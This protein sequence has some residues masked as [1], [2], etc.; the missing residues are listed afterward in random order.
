VKLPNSQISIILIC[1]SGTNP[2]EQKSKHQ[3]TENGVM[4]TRK[5]WGKTTKKNEGGLGGW[6]NT[7]KKDNW[8]ANLS[9]RGRRA[10]I[11]LKPRIL[12]LPQKLFPQT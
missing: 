4:G 7:T 2:I 1:T 3:F 5:E 9:R 10:E 12:D 11:T 8:G 6:G